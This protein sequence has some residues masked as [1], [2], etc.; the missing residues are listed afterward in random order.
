PRPR[1]LADLAA[2]VLIQADATAA[3][4]PWRLRG[5]ARQ[6][7]QQLHLWLGLSVGVAYA[8]IALSGSALAWQKPWLRAAYPQLAGHTLPDATQRADVLARIAAQW[9]AQGL[10]AVDLPLAGL[11]VWQLYFADGT[12]RYVDPASG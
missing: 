2:D 6:W 1:G 7:L 3:A 10:R 8:L 4:K 9:P 12:R 5:R 11:P